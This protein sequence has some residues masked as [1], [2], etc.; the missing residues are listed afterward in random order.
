MLK[1]MPSTKEN[2]KQRM[3]KGIYHPLTATLIN[4][5][6]SYFAD[7]RPHGSCSQLN[8]LIASTPYK[9][10]EASCSHSETHDQRNFTPKT[11]L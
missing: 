11:L 9:F 5:G 2:F 3:M 8:N 6:W 10:K 1:K 4:N 7:V